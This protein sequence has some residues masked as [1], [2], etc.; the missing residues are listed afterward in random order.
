MSGKGKEK[1]KGKGREHDVKK[2]KGQGR[3]GQR[4][5]SLK[6]IPVTKPGTGF[7]EGRTRRDA[8][9]ATNEQLRSFYEYWQKR[10]LSPEEIRK[11]MQEN[12]KTY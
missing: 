11:R 7:Q 10:G 8:I 6:K 4:E 3:R 5:K 2:K 1:F 12:N 9:S